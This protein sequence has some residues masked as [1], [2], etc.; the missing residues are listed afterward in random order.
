MKRYEAKGQRK[1]EYTPQTERA[2]NNSTRSARRGVE[3]YQHT[4]SLYLGPSAHVATGSEIV[5]PVFRQHA[6]QGPRC[7]LEVE[8][9]RRCAHRL[10][11][12]CNS[13]VIKKTDHFFF[14]LGEPPTSWTALDMVERRGEC[15]IRRQDGGDIRGGRMSRRAEAQFQ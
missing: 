14:V 15:D 13:R 7:Q 4:V 1:S 6:C 8:G 12:P 3:L 11:A 2:C 9:T 10:S 5:G